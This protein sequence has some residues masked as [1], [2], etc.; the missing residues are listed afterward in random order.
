[1]VLVDEKGLA[2]GLAF[3]PLRK[4]IAVVERVGLLDRPDV[5]DPSFR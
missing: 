4:L 5:P 2:L 1:L 3:V